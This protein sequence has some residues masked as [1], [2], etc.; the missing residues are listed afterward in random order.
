MKLAS[1]TVFVCF[2]YSTSFN[3]DDFSSFKNSA[4]EARQLRNDILSLKLI[5]QINK[6][7]HAALRTKE[8]VLKVRHN[9]LHI[10]LQ[11]NQSKP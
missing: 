7:S 3:S 2:N 6:L 5:V 8:R 11:V 9:V 1:S 4:E 10:V